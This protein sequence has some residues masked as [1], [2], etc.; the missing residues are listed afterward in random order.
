MEASQSS[1]PTSVLRRRVAALVIDGLLI[2]AI[3]LAIFFAL[4]STK[5]EV[6]R[7][8]RAGDIAPDTTLYGIFALGDT[9]VY[10]GKAA[11]LLLLVFL[12]WFGYWI[13]LQGIKGFTPGKALM[14][15][16]LV[17]D[18]GTLPP[19]MPR[20]LARQLLLVADGFPYVIPGLTG[21][22]VAMTNARNQRIGDKR[23]GTLVIRTEAVADGPADSGPAPGQASRI[24]PPPPS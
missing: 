7:G 17:K 20:T 2:G 3:T 12:S 4:A 8:L 9:S 24:P 22:I 13:V 11:L 14:G 23:A 18:D 10:G 21:F 1:A 6:V 16:R 15:L 19:G 5:T